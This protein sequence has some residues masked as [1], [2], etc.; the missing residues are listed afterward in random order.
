MKCNPD[1]NVAKVSQ[2]SRGISTGAVGHTELGSN[3][4]QP[5]PEL[6]AEPQVSP[7]HHHHH[8]SLRQT[9]FL[10]I[11]AFPREFTIFY[12]PH[13]SVAER[14]RERVEISRAVS[15]EQDLVLLF[16]TRK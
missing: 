7:W 16:F 15:H 9:F 6:L 1:I 2:H 10:I 14:E 13:I 5:A 8:C 12:S 11:I 3:S 4:C